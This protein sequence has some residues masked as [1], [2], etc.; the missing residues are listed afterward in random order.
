MVYED[1]Q[2][3]PLGVLTR[4][5]DWMGVDPAP[6][7]ESHHTGELVVNRAPTRPEYWVWRVRQHMDAHPSGR[8]YRA[9]T[10]LARQGA[11]VPIR[12]AARVSNVTRRLINDFA[13][14][15]CMGLNAEFN[16][17]LHEFGYPV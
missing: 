1:F 7:A 10:A 16:L 3:D 4:I 17:K 15:Q 5:A 2:A 14:D 9:L 12:P 8:P 11:K 13:K 6:F